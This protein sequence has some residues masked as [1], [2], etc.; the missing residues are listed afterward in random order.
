MAPG[1]LGGH[2]EGIERSLRR[3]PN[4]ETQEG[5]WQPPGSNSHSLCHQL[6]CGFCLLIESP[7]V[8]PV[9]WL[10]YLFWPNPAQVNFSSLWPN[11]SS[12]EDKWAKSQSSG[13][14]SS[15]Q[16]GYDSPRAPGGCQVLYFVQFTKV[17]LV[18]YRVFQ[19]TIQTFIRRIQHPTSELGL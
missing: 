8:F 6:S 9:V 17:L 5:P 15:Y 1:G 18:Q 11:N 19:Q 10:I 13:K 4:C 2:R 16:K 7:T 14:Q 12:L 3:K